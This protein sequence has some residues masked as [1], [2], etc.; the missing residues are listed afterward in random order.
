MPLF[1]SSK[2]PIFLLL[3]SAFTVVACGGG[4]SGGGGGGGNGANSE[5]LIPKDHVQDGGPGPDGIPSIDDPVF[6]AAATIATV[7][8]D[9]MV[10]AIRDEGQVKIYPHDIMDYHEIVNDGSE[11]N[12]F[13]L[14]YCPLT[15]SAVAWKGNASHVDPTFGT[16]GLLYESNLILYDRQTETLW[17][18]MLQVGINGPRIRERPEQLQ[19]I[20]AT[21]ATLQA[22]YPDA[23]V[24]TRDTGH[25]R[26][27]DRYPYGDYLNS[28]FMLFQV[29][30]FD[31]RLFPKARIIG[32]YDDSNAKAYQIPG[33][34][35][36]TQTINDQFGEQSIVVVGNSDMRFAAIF[37]RR[38]SDGTILTFSPIQDDLPNIMSDDAAVSG[39]RAGEQLGVTRSY[40]S[41]WFAWG[42]FHR[43][44]EIH[45]N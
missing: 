18:Q 45:F 3:L 33:F 38:L 37:D 4:G 30:H 10:I 14:S 9:D 29:R 17:S 19:I 26:E 16:S 43:D 22:M 34:G 44:S 28:G 5:W 39:P 40:K 27:Y 25:I 24:M 7:D 11:T 20:E 8:P 21:F 31:N 36:I 12:P 13:V 1:H 6:E 35:P 32:I 15:D 2:K 41:M 23:I 42:A